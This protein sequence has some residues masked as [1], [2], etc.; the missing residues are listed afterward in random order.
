VSFNTLLH[1]WARQADKGDPEAPG[2]AEEILRLMERLSREGNNDIVPDVYSFTIVIQAW[3]SLQDETGVFHSKLLLRRMENVGNQRL[4]VR[5]NTVTYT[6]VLGA[7]AKSKIPSAGADAMDIFDRMW[8]RYESG[9]DQSCKPDSAAFSAVISCIA[10]T[11]DG[12]GGSGALHVLQRMKQLAKEGHTNVAPNARTYT[13]VIKAL[14]TSR[15]DHAM[16]RAMELL[17]EMEEAFQAGNSALEPSR[18][19]YNVVLSLIA[20]SRLEDKTEPAIKLFREMKTRNRKSCQPDSVTYNTLLGLCATNVHGSTEVKDATMAFALEIFRE[21]LHHKTVRPN[22]LTFCNFLKSLRR[23][24]P[25]NVDAV[26]PTVSLCCQLGLLTNRFL[27]ELSYMIEDRDRLAYLLRLDVMPDFLTV[28]DFP[29][30]WSQHNARKRHDVR[31]PKKVI[32]TS[33][34][35]RNSN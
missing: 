31:N 14:R 26:E 28:L 23:L 12:P 29:P 33:P 35:F 2:R 3:S 25:D 9:G 5:P 20:T 30:E 22:A 17:E 32:V 15:D 8:D 24:T 1:A 13:S 4:A 34:Y 7:I 16:E 27:K 6:S 11:P 19:H 21:I 10:A 18:I